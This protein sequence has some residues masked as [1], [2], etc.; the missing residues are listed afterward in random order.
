MNLKKT[1]LG[2]LIF[3][4]CSLVLLFYFSKSALSLAKNHSQKREF[5]AQAHREHWI[6]V[7]IHGS[8][9]TGLG[10]LSFFDVLNDRPH[11]TFYQ[12]LT[13]KLRNDPYN[14]QEQIMLE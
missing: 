4:T 10:L 7:F 6:T 5:H 13:K 9:H 11:K 12:K 1:L 2:F 8:F 3:I 14:Y